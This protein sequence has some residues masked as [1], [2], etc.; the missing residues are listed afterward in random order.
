MKLSKYA[1]LC[2]VFVL[3]CSTSLARADVRREIAFPDLPGYQTLKCDFHMHTVF[4]D[5]R[6]WPTVRVDEAWRLGLDALA[7]TDHIEYQPHKDDVPTQHNR[8]YELARDAAKA[9]NLLLLRA[10]E[11]TRDTPPGH[12]NAIGLSDVNALATEG[13]VDAV[14]AAN[15]Q[16][17]FVIWNHHEWQGVE[18]GRWLDVH[19]KLF[20]N[21]WLHAMEVCN[22]ESYYPRAHQWCLDKNLTMMGNTDIH[23]P[24]L[25]RSNTP[26]DHRTLTLV[27]AKER[28]PASLKESLRAAARP[29]GSR[30]S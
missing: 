4:S 10:A 14:E 26:D 2:F 24:D 5:G 21:Q 28:T 6:V 11:I 23:Q 30:T 16:G 12:F 25:R 20:E 7:I 27:F 9:K 3:L 13:F 8:P 19:T 17:A 29:S 15:Q 18:R 22:G 1:T